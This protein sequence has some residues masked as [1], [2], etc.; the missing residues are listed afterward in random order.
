MKPIVYLVIS[1]LA[2][3][4]ALGQEPILRGGQSF[5]LRLAGVPQE[6]QVSISQ[7]YTI[8]DG[9]TIKLLYI[10]EMKAA[11]LRP[12]KLAR[13]IEAAYRAAQIFSKPNVVIMLSEAGAVQRYVSV[14]G[15]VKASRSVNHTP[16]LRL[17]DVIAQCGGFSDFANPKKVKLTRDGKVSFHDLSKTSNTDNVVLQPNDIVTVPARRLFNRS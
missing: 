16:G 3:G 9:G 4:V 10:P 15:E 7:S 17:F 11:G 8:S 12:T 6:D 1:L 13:N 14:L 2:A 5:G